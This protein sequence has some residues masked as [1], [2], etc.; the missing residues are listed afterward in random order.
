MPIPEGDGL[1]SRTLIR[2]RV[3]A[4]I[5]QAI[6]DGTIKPGER[7]DDTE[8]LAW[9]GVSRTPIRQALYVL[10]AEGLVETAPQAYTRVVM[11]RREDAM[12][13]LRAIGV[14]I[15]GIM[16]LSL[17]AA[18]END[19]N[20]LALRVRKICAA[21]RNHDLE[22]TLTASD[23]YHVAL[24]DLC[25][26]QPMRRLIEQSGVSLSYYV[27]AVYRSLDID[28]DSV[29]GA[30]EKIAH[31]LEQHDQEEAAAAT[32]ALFGVSGV[33]RPIIN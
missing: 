18:T 24:I 33:D 30:Y 22:G 15:A 10:T 4:Q 2:D 16:D 29:L 23:E 19:F 12:E 3:Y 11:P 1:R 26:N 25:S 9:L 17:P 13:Y 21:V 32:K 14:L 7:L 31:A 5:K 8:L 28:W 6:L 20:Q 27:L